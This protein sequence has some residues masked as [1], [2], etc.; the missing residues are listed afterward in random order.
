M[1]IKNNFLR[2][3][4][5][6][7]SLIL[8]FSSCSPK[9]FRYEVERSSKTGAADTYLTKVW[10]TT[11]RVNETKLTDSAVRLAVHGIIFR[12]VTA[13]GAQPALGGKKAFELE[14]THKKFFDEFFDKNTGRYHEFAQ[15]IGDGI[16]AS[17]RIRLRDAPRFRNRFKVGFDVSI[18][19]RA[20]REYL[21][22]QGVIEKFGAPF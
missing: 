9:I 6:F 17:D 5:G 3:T 10:L 8:L 11:N 18:K 13:D 14:K 19:V 4:I 16:Q 1:K 2:T 21:E 22:Q 20:L 7:I 15:S 12:G